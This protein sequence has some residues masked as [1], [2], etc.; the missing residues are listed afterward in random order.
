[1]E[2]IVTDEAYL[3]VRLCLYIVGWLF[4]KG[5]FLSFKKQQRVWFELNSDSKNLELR[6]DVTL[7]ILNF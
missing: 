7:R 2:G 6:Q 1:M 4:K 3:F 5:T